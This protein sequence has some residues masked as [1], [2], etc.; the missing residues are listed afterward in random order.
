MGC[1]RRNHS[2]STRLV[3]LDPVSPSSLSEPP[4]L[5]PPPPR[6]AV[7]TSIMLPPQSCHRTNLSSHSPVKH[8]YEAQR[9]G[10]CNLKLKYCSQICGRLYFLL[11]I[12]F[13]DLFEER[14][15]LT[16]VFIATV[17]ILMFLI[18]IL[19][20]VVGARDTIISELLLEMPPCIRP[21]AYRVGMRVRKLT[22]SIISRNNPNA[23]LQN[24]QEPRTLSTHEQL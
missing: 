15:A 5:F 14:G 18:Y 8:V 19:H 20:D 13:C 6:N 23:V 10:R 4:P 2:T 17:C 7:V 1:G 12:V 24:S 21:S 22:S 9:S 3:T 11:K 16:Y